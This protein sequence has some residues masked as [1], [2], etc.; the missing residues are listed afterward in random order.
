MIHGTIGRR[1]VLM[2]VQHVDIADVSRI[3]CRLDA[4]HPLEVGAV[5]VLAAN[6]DGEV[7]LEYFR[8]TRW[9]EADASGRCQAG[10]EF[11]PVPADAP[12]LHDVVAYL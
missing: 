9:L 10:V 6:I 7:H 5:G 2:H 1:A 12:S 4:S 8:V 11:L 3:G